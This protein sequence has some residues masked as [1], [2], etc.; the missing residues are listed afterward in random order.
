MNIS[1]LVV[2][3]VIFVAISSIGF[4]ASRWRRAD[5]S[6]LNEWGLAGRTLGTVINWF[7]KSPLVK[8][9]TPALR[10]QTGKFPP[11]LEICTFRSISGKLRTYTSNEPVSSEE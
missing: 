9:S 10:A 4:F 1:Q 7:L 5:M 6:V 8:N 3:A 2:F 11:P